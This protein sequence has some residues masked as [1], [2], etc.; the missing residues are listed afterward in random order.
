MSPRKKPD[1]SPASPALALTPAEAVP[2]VTPVA[3]VETDAAAPARP[4]RPLDNR[5][6]ANGLYEVGDL[7]GI[8]G[9]DPFR[10]RSYRR[11]AEAIEPLP[12]QMSD[13]IADPKKV[14]AIPGIGKAMCA[15]LQE[16]FR[17]GK[18]S[19]HTELLQKYRPSMLELLKIQGLGPKTI[20]LLWSAYQVCDIE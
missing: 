20:A 6:L 18:L 9:D 13:I 1:A 14:L 3:V 17:E 19:L 2:Q 12:Y 5:A 15:H 11:A 4:A 16:I 10:I 7:M 8:N